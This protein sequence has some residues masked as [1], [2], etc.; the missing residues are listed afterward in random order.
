MILIH[1]T[2][3]WLGFLSFPVIALVLL[4]LAGFGF[5]QMRAVKTW[6]VGLPIVQW[7]A[8]FLVV[9]G[10]KVLRAKK[11][12]HFMQYEHRYWISPN[13]DGWKFPDDAG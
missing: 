5:R 1:V 6:F 7:P 3:W 11:Y 13:T 9:A 4:S 12:C 2:A 10:C 8:M